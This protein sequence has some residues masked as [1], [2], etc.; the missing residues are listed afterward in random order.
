[1]TAADA[2]CE[3]FP[4][5]FLAFHRRDGRRS[6][7]TNASRAVLQHLALTGPVSIGEAAKHLERAQSVVS[8]I[9]SQLE[10][11]G[12]LEREPDPDNRRRTLVWLTEQGFERLRADAD[13]LDRRLVAEAM[14]H[15]DE[16][17]RRGLIEGLNAL[18]AAAGREPR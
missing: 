4:A 7:L 8:D 1:M 12:L 10:G 3:A 5:T 16:T 9:V 17:T 13:V 11:H 14:D 18:V 15:L 2:F 6:E